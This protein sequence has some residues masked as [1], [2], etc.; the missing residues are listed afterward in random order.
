MAVDSLTLLLPHTVQALSHQPLRTDSYAPIE[1]G[2]RLHRK[3]ALPCHS[4]S[5]TWSCGT[6][7]VSLPEDTLQLQGMKLDLPLSESK[8]NPSSS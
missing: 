1:R 7:P 8:P 4:Q 3:Y 2:S 5:L 6:T